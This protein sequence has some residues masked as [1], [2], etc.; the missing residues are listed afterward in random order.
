MKLKLL[1]FLCCLSFVGLNAQ[2]T[3][4][5]IQNYL[6]RTHESLGVTLEDVQNIKIVSDY[7]TQKTGLQHVVVQQTV[8]EIPVFNAFATVTI[9][10]SSV[11]FVGNSLIANIN[12]LTNTSAP[13]FNTEA[14]ISKAAQGLEINVPSGLEII[15]SI[16][17][18]VLFNSGSISQED[19][20]V[21]LVYQPTTHTK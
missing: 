17:G 10:D 19:I 2:T 4:T 7:E 21:K 12:S 5:L 1:L 13:S 15:G 9:K 20:P 14:S 8:N 16:D 3:E 6:E 18:G 11:I